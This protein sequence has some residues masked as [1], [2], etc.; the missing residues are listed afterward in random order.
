MRSNDLFRGTPYNFVQFT[1]LQELLAG[2]L[3][4]TMGSYT[5]LSD[6]LHVYENDLENVTSHVAVDAPTSE[7]NLLLPKDVSDSIW[8]SL[9]KAVDELIAPGLR[10]N[11]IEDIAMEPDNSAVRNMLLIVAADSARRRAY[12]EL[13]KELSAR[14]TNPLL[15]LASRRWYER[16]SHR[17]SVPQ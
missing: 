16:T 11:D 17:Q 7:D 6:S 12:D 1:M 10:E 9:N 15:S 3:G 4:V 2:W 5:Q 13:A 14:C 8:S